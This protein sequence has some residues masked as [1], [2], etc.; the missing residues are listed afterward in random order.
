M[1]AFYLQIK[2][3]HIAAVLASGGLFALRGAL[4]LGG[5]KWAMAAPLRYLSYTIDTVLL[6]A[7]LMLLTALK[8]NPFVV[9]W[10]S[11][12]LGL[13]VVYVVLGSLALKRARSQRSRA[14]FYAAAL[15][16]FA[17]MYFVARAHHPLGLLQG[18]AS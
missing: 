16:T 3:V 7:A 12:K 11:V 13:L 8:L 4:V 18:L 14:L 1:L 6:T 10:L 17:F 15:A 5:V 9:P 2:M